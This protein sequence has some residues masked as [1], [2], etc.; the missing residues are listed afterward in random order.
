MA[1]MKAPVDQYKLVYFI[2]FWLGIVCLIPK[3]LLMAGKLSFVYT[4][5]VIIFHLSNPLELYSEW[6]LDV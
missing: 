5:L 4:V 1:T 2:F 6:I 3:F